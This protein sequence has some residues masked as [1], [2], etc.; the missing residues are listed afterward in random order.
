MNIFSGPADERDSKVMGRSS[1]ARAADSPS[2]RVRPSVRGTSRQ[3]AAQ[4]NA[5]PPQNLQQTLLRVPPYPYVTTE[6][7]GNTPLLQTGSGTRASGPTSKTSTRV[8]IHRKDIAS[9][10]HDSP[11][12]KLRST[13]HSEHVLI[14]DTHRAGPRP[15]GARAFVSSFLSILINT[16]PCNRNFIPWIGI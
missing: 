13:L 3:L 8:V 2:P 12:A 1:G 11:E 16:K 14:A 4:A 9:I 10:N 7:T 5:S 15:R 6:R